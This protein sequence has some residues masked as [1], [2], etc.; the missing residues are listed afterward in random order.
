[1]LVILN[2]D[3][4]NHLIVLDKL[5]KIIVLFKAQYS[6]YIILYVFYIN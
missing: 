4:L 5:V 2:K 1:M 3:F 6:L